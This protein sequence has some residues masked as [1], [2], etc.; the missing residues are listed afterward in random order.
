MNDPNEMK[1]CFLYYDDFGLVDETRD[2]TEGC[3]YFNIN[4]PGNHP[5]EGR[6]P[7]CKLVIPDDKGLGHPNQTECP[8]GSTAITSAAQCAEAA[9]DLGREFALFGTTYKQQSATGGCGIGG[10]AF[11]ERCLCS[12]QNLTFCHQACNEDSVCVGFGTSHNGGSCQYATTALTCAEGCRQKKINAGNVG[13][14]ISNPGSGYG[15]CFVKQND[16]YMP[17]PTKQYLFAL[18]FAGCPM[19]T[20]SNA[21]LD[22]WSMLH[23]SVAL[24]EINAICSKTKDGT[25]TDLQ[26]KSM[27]RS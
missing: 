6:V 27:L 5:Q 13:P 2:C 25:A 15:G 1:G 4:L 26:K 16:T 12:K 10:D 9:R 23:D 20:L 8:S 17:P 22:W 18:K 7:Y 3:L 14:I 21:T 24:D 19:P 11:H